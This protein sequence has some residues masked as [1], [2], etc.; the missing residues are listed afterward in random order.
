M[1]VYCRRLFS[2]QLLLIVGCAL[3]CGGATASCASL[4]ALLEQPKEG[5][6]RRVPANR[7]A[8]GTPNRRAGCRPLQMHNR[9]YGT[10][11]TYRCSLLVNDVVLAA[12]DGHVWPACVCV[13]CQGVA[14]QRSVRV[15]TLREERCER[16]G[17]PRTTVR[18]HSERCWHLQHQTRWLNIHTLSYVPSSLDK[19]T[20]WMRWLIHTN[21]CFWHHHQQQHTSTHT[22]KHLS[23]HTQ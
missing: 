2:Q 22:C 17:V 4:S 8:A 19:H 11:T 12:Q 14:R 5:S 9:W 23:P 10:P 16:C 15:S 20:S 13:S 6:K 7:S 1:A 21:H 3:R 18:G